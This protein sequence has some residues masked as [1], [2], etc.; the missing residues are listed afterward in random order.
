[1]LAYLP[2]QLRRL[3][4]MK[5]A[6]G[7]PFHVDLSKW[8]VRDVSRWLDTLT[9]GQVCFVLR[10]RCGPALHVH[11]P[12]STRAYLVRCSVRCSTGS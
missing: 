6:L 9:L 2:L 7:E 10:R 12:V 1:L 5:Q 4:E 3:E 8:R 11:T